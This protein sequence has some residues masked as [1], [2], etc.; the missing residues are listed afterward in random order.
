MISELLFFKLAKVSLL[1]RSELLLDVFVPPLVVWWGTIRRFRLFKWREKELV[2]SSDETEW[3]MFRC[4]L[5]FCIKGLE[6][7]LGM[8]VFGAPFVSEL[9]VI[10]A[11]IFDE[12]IEV[13]MLSFLAASLEIEFLLELFRINGVIRLLSSLEDFLGASFFLLSRFLVE[14]FILGLVLPFSKINGFPLFVLGFLGGSRSTEEERYV[15]SSS[16]LDSKDEWG[17]KRESWVWT[18]STSSNWNTSILWMKE[19]R[20][21]FGAGCKLDVVTIWGAIV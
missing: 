21:I 17:M 4:W 11:E 8:V 14:L 13:W 3:F 7:G 12:D 5:K 15:Y 1:F 6:G 9:S 10:L 18:E 20:A 2:F 19:W 16:S